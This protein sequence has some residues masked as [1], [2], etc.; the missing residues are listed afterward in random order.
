MKEIVSIPDWLYSFL[1]SSL[2]NISK[3]EWSPDWFPVDIPP[4]SFRPGRYILQGLLLVVYPI[5]LAYDFGSRAWDTAWDALTKATSALFKIEIWAQEAV[6]RFLDL[7]S[8]WWDAIWGPWLTYLENLISEAR[9]VA[10]NAWNWV[11]NVNTWIIDKLNPIYTWIGSIL[12]NYVTKV[13]LADLFKPVQEF[14]DFWL[15]VK[16]EMVAFFTDPL[17]WVYD[18]MDEFFERYW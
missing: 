5:N 9:G 12:Q 16:D 18:K 15:M 10:Y 4:F 13:S 1:G 6:S 8:D 17:Q 3:G 2:L 14:M 11:S 7:A